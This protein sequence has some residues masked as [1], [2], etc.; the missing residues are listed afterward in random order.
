VLK[1]VD[2]VR[3]HEKSFKRWLLEPR[4]SSTLLADDFLAH[5]YN[6]KNREAARQAVMKR[7]KRN[8]IERR[9]R[10]KTTRPGSVV[11]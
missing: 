2:F 11:L 1:F 10:T 5:R 3:S 8:R 4:G 9:A 7:Q 6:Y